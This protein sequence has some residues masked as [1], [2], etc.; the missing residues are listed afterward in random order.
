LFQIPAHLIV[1]QDPEEVVQDE[2]EPTAEHGAVGQSLLD[3]D[4]AP[5]R[6]KKNYPD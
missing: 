5:D 1:G 4:P 2:D 3:R 6:I